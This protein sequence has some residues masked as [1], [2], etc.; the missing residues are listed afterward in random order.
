MQDAQA[1]AVH[2]RTVAARTAKLL[3]TDL[4]SKAAACCKPLD[5]AQTTLNQLEDH[6]LKVLNQPDIIPLL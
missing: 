4:T 3:L 2:R 1:P 5:A 6:I